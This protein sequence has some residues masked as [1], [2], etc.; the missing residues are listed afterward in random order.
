MF[1]YRVKLE[2]SIFYN[3]LFNFQWCFLCS[4]ASYGWLIYRNL[5]SVY[6][7]HEFYEFSTEDWLVQ[8]IDNW[9][10]WWFS[11]KSIFIQ[12]LFIF[13]LLIHDEQSNKGS[14]VCAIND[15]FVELPFDLPI[16]IAP[17]WFLIWSGIIKP[18]L[19]TSCFYTIVPL[20]SHQS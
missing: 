3:L 12:S 18:K 1:C 15:R 13:N 10:G 9:F 17:F 11:Y 16:S 2:Y 7:W 5:R 4:S 14:N 6:N 8:K 19:N 20:S